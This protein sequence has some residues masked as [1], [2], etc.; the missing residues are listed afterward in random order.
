MK[1]DVSKERR[2]LFDSFKT[3]FQKKYFP[4]LDEKHFIPDFDYAPL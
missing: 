3:R 2:P 1:E 4:F